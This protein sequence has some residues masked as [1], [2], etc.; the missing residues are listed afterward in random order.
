V[1]TFFDLVKAAAGHRLLGDDA[2]YFGNAF[3][4]SVSTLFSDSGLVSFTGDTR[5]RRYM[6]TMPNRSQPNRDRLIYST[7][8]AAGAVQFMNPLA[9]PA[10]NGEEFWL[11]RDFNFSTWLN[12]ANETAQSL[13]FNQEMTLRGQTDLLRYT[14]GVPISRPQWMQAVFGAPYPQSFSDGP[15]PMLRWF[16]L[17]TSTDSIQGEIVIL[18]EA[19]LAANS[20]LIFQFA[21]PYAHVHQSAWTMTRSVLTPF[22]QSSA[23]E[24]PFDLFVL[25]MVWR[26]LQQKV[27]NL[28]GEARTRWEANLKDAARDYAECIAANGV[29]AVARREIGFSSP[30]MSF[31]GGIGWGGL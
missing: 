5:W 2:A 15:P 1:S 8:L 27:R 18:L 29:K 24:P 3:T 21:R 20:Q 26:A 23:V 30:G 25:G 28:T 7:N 6:L 11:F 31:P 9:T 14:V 19:S 17:N 4:G 10:Q 16:R 12:F 13:F 22:G